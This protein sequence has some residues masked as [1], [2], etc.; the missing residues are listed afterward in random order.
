MEDQA[1]AYWGQIRAEQAQIRADKNRMND[2]L[3]VD[4]GR[5]DAHYRAQIRRVEREMQEIDEDM[6][7]IDWRM[8]DTVFGI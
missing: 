4:I 6:L 2:R 5:V 1:R 3:R 8:S 7:G